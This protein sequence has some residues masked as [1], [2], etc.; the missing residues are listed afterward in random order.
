MKH[1]CPI[2]KQPQRIHVCLRTELAE[3]KNPECDLF[4]VTLEIGQHELLTQEQIVNWK[5]INERV[6]SS[7]RKG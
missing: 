2:C 4:E 5:A 1:Q 7:Q 3:C 6:N